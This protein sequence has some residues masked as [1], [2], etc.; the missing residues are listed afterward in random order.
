MSIGY[1]VALKNILP[2]RERRYPP[3]PAS[4]SPLD[5]SI[6]MLATADDVCAKDVPHG[7]LQR[8]VCRGDVSAADDL[9]NYALIVATYY[10]LFRHNDLNFAEDLIRILKS[11]RLTIEESFAV[12]VLEAAHRTA[13]TCNVRALC[14]VSAVGWGALL[15]ELIALHFTYDAKAAR[16]LKCKVVNEFNRY[17]ISGMWR[18]IYAPDPRLY[19]IFHAADRVEPLPACRPQK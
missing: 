10:V 3:L 14:R 12:D 13:T 1:I 4:W 5:R 11:R 18:I 15:K 6:E 19:F 7:G 8:L 9:P 17:Y 2:S 16:R